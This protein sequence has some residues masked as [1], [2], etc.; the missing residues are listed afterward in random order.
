ML[1]FDSLILF[2]H[3]DVLF[4]KYCRYEIWIV[5][6]RVLKALFLSRISFTIARV[7]TLFPPFTLIGASSL[8]RSQE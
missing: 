2:L 3:A 8:L 6:F 4:S 7:L 5:D 1:L